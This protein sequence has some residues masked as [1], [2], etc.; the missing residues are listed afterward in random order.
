MLLPM[1]FP[2]L[3]VSGMMFMNIRGNNLIPIVLLCFVAVFSIIVTI[4]KTGLP[5]R[6]YPGMI[7][8]I[9]TSLVLIFGLRS[10]YILGVD[11]HTEY[12]I[13]QQTLLYGHWGILLNSPLSS[14]LSI[15]ILPTI[16][17]LILNIN[18]QYLFKLLY[19]ILFS[20]SPM[21][22]YILSRKYI[23]DSSAF[24][25]SL[26]Y[27]SQAYFLSAGFSPRTSMGILFFGLSVMV[28]FC[29]ELTN[30]NKHLLF[31]VFINMGH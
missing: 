9:S 30:F 22:V 27:M 10:N 15:S 5:W 4:K 12:Y 28:L 19:P 16:Y 21:I 17:Q 29:D 7:F 2:L 20:T 3:S 18:P 23:G 24:L 6:L 11:I 8:C 14:C 31:V 13:F 26:F 25:A 1:L